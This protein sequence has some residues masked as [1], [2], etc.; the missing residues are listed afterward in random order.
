MSYF[1]T[2]TTDIKFILMDGYSYY[3]IEDV[4]KFWIKQKP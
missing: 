2:K 3:L 1:E 4:Y